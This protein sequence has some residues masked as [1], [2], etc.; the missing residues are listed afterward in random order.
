MH[1]LDVLNLIISKI[2]AKK[3]LEIGVDKGKVF[4]KVNVNKK[5]AVD[6]V[7]KIPFKKKLSSCIKDYHNIFNEYFEITSDKFFEIKQ[8][9]LKALSGIDLIF[10]DGL[11]AYEQAYRDVLNSLK[12]VSQKGIIIMHDCNPSTESEAKTECLPQNDSTS[13]EDKSGSLWCGDV[14]KAVVRLRSERAYLNI[15]VLDCDFGIG[16][17]SNGKN[18]SALNLD[19]K[20]ISNLEYSDLDKNRQTLLNLKQPEYLHKFLDIFVKTKF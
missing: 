4:L 19:E 6:P 7:L 16:L 12:Y 20:S 15:F 14:W 18:E 5:L 9:H 3:Y 13:T 2:K 11:H 10:V 8:N 1:R 17:I